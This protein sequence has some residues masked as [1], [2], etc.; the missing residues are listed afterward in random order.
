MWR[1]SGNCVL[2]NDANESRP[3]DPSAATEQT[4]RAQCLQKS[5]EAKRCALHAESLRLQIEVAHRE[6]LNK[7]L[8]ESRDQ[9]RAL[10][11]KVTDQQESLAHERD[12]LHQQLQAAKKSNAPAAD[13]AYVHNRI[14]TGS[15]QNG[16]AVW[17]P[18]KPPARNG[19]YADEHF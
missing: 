6:H 7:K 1:R 9:T 8:Q 3:C 5:C 14:P 19:Q 18:T 12:K 16:I 13:Q 17:A 15:K 10:Q 4:L 2:V 11:L